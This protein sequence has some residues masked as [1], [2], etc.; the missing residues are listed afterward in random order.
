[1]HILFV[2]T[3]NP[4]RSPM[5]EGI[6]RSLAGGCPE[7]TC[8][9]GGLAACEGERAS[10]N[11]VKACREIEVDISSHRAHQINREDL[12]EAS[13]IAVVSPRH[14]EALLRAG[15]PKEK[16]YPLGNLRDPY[17]GGLDEYR[18]SRDEI[19]KAVEILWQKVNNRWKEK[20]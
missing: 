11:A 9:S 6:F 4:C 7:I 10:S 8:S 2:C 3:G 20:K 17:G 16:I 14:G 1:M 19:K 13:L 18:T 15:V 5:A 12:Q